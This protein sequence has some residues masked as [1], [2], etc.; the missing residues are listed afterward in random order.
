MHA[1][2]GAAT[3]ISNLDP[4]RADNA[5]AVSPGRDVW[6]CVCKRRGRLLFRILLTQRGDRIVWYFYSTYN[7]SCGSRLDE[8]LYDVV[9]DSPG[10]ARK[11]RLEMY[12]S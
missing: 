1:R 11:H 5:H 6:K 10:N 3:V 8:L 4:D 12:D 2:A 7:E 9:N